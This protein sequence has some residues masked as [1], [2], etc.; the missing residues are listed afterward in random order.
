MNPPQSQNGAF[1]SP[2]GGGLSP[3]GSPL[4][5]PPANPTKD[6][7]KIK[8][9]VGAGC[10][11][12]GMVSLCCLSGAA[13]ALWPASP[14]DLEVVSAQI[15][16]IP[17]DPDAPP[18]SPGRAPPHEREVLRVTYR[19]EPEAEVRLGVLRGRSTADEDGEGVVDMSLSNDERD[20]TVRARLTSRV[21]YDSPSTSVQVTAE[22]PYLLFRSARGWRCNIGP[23]WAT[24]ERGRFSLRA[25]PGGSIA[26]GSSTGTDPDVSDPVLRQGDPSRLFGGGEYTIPVP[27]R[28][29]FADGTTLEETFGIERNISVPLIT[30]RFRR[31]ING[32]VRVPVEGTG[33][34]I[35][36]FGGAGSTSARAVLLGTATTVGDIGRVA[37]VGRR[38][39]RRQCGSYAGRSGR[40][41]LFVRQRHAVI[42]FY[43]RRTGQLLDT[44]TITARRLSCPRTVNVAPGSGD[45]FWRESEA[46]IASVRAWLEQQ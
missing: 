17:P 14:P 33:T 6:T 35:L 22:R 25:P 23:C 38:L 45:I 36:W 28:V 18:A 46:P 42:R 19:T 9:I 7:H 29:T 20:R 39:Q 4:A 15:V 5:V 1:P 26:L 10:G 11:A 44:H 12:L 43:D 21:D 40:R 30:A 8:R 24:T 3:L 32:P 2:P 41:R 16:T 37:I 27:L 34:A 13:I 31:V